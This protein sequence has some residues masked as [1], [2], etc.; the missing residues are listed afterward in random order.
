[1]SKIDVDKFVADLL[2]KYGMCDSNE[3]ITLQDLVDA[4]TSQKLGY[5]DGQ[6][7]RQIDI[8]KG[9]HYLCIKDDVQGG[10]R[11]DY[12]KGNVYISKKDGTLPSN[13][14]NNFPINSDEYFRRTHYG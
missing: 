4:L 13:S 12:T 1:M 5:N 9:E 3:P 11:I 8:K 2:C 7:H 14:G 6:I 10:G